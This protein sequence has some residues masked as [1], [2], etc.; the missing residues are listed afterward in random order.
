MRLVKHV[1]GLRKA[2]YPYR[3]WFNKV[4]NVHAENGFDSRL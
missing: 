3:M 2:S 1:S 4:S